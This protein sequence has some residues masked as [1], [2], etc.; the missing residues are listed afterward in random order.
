ME[1][2]IIRSKRKSISIQISKEAEV[3]VRVPIDIHK[4]VI[5]EFVNSN[6]KWILEKLIMMRG[7]NY[8][9]SRF[10]LDYGHK[11]LFRGKEFTLTETDK[12]AIIFHQDLLYIP[13][14]LSRD[15]IKYLLIKMYNHQAKNIISFKVNF[16]S[17]IMNVTPKALKIN[18]ASTRWGSCSGKKSLN[19]SW[20][21]IF[22]K[23][24]IIDY[25]VVHELA[26]IKQL[27]HSEKFW[28][29]VKKVIPDYNNRRKELT[30]LGIK[31][32]NQNWD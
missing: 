31:L 18:S 32:R 12:N 14:G 6:E 28:D 22:A 3:L 2:R 5:D 25:L 16:Y 7:I 26:H 24:E 20:K 21:I 13:S 29:E 23:D 17:K 30:E 10:V 15:Q 19:F 4:S 11:V 9:K 27:N 8:E 1:Y